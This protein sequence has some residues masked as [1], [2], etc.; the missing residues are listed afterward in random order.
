MKENN[1]KY[2]YT[3]LFIED[4]EIILNN[5]TTYLKKIFSNVLTARDGEEA[6][7]LYNKE[8]PEIIIADIHIP[9]INGLTL[10]EMIR[11]KDL[12][13]KLIV[14]TGH[15]TTKF[16]LQATSLK[17][18]N[19]LQKPIS[20]LKLKESLNKAIEE[21]SNYKLVKIQNIELKNGY[22]W[23]IRNKILKR[24]EELIE[25]TKKETLLL[26]LLF[27]SVEKVFSY[28]EILYQVWN[29]FDDEGNI[30]SLKNLVRRLRL[31]LPE[32]T[33]ENVF[34]EGYRIKIK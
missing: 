7:K 13:V 9:K 4:E 34:K 12:D 19:Y 16:L 33:L 24:K 28:D 3:I 22:S 6:L 32:E 17:L 26:E 31:K 29:D 30:N 20:R 5:Y 27:S 11:E 15:V 10:L 23:D 2:P 25:L 14:L 8:K 21:I 1:E 18:I